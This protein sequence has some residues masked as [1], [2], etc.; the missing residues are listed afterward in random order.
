MS[1]VI[2]GPLSFSPTYILLALAFLAAVL[3]G[4]LM[5][6]V[7]GVPVVGK[8]IDIL[9]ITVFS[10]RLGFVLI[11]FDHYRD[12]LFDIINIRDGGFHLVSGIFG[13]GLVCAWKLRR[14][15]RDRRVLGGAL[16]VGLVVWLG[17]MGLFRVLEAQ[18]LGLPALALRQLDD[19]PVLLSEIVGSKP[20][21]INLWATWCPPCIREMPVLLEAQQRH[22]EIMFLFVNQGEQAATI[23]EF[24][25]R[26]Q[27]E[28]E[29]VLLDPHTIL[30]RETGHRSLP[31]TLFYTADGRMVDTH[32]GELSSATLAYR[33]QRLATKP[34][35]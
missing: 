7:S 1:A 26:Q 29:N 19:T 33:L 34:L 17:G 9:V 11:Y 21:A 8:L 18:S 6:R 4:G 16:A 13:F 22:P 30:G 25:E 35:P 15:P 27:L 32:L 28:L 23:M 24:L 20:V 12:N 31:V 10:A 2:V 3:V 14:Y 5:G